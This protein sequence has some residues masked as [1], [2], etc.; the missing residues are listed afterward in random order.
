MKSLTACPSSAASK[1]YATGSVDLGSEHLNP[2]LQQDR[3]HAAQ[4]VALPSDSFPVVLCSGMPAQGTTTRESNYVA[5]C[6]SGL[7]RP[8][9]SIMKA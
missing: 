5:D 6:D 7:C 1:L 8:V 2:T 3:A 4:S 9:V